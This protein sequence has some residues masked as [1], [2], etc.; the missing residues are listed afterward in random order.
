MATSTAPSA[1]P[2]KSSGFTHLWILIGI[3]IVLAIIAAGLGIQLKVP[4]F[5][6]TKATLGAGL[7]VMAQLV[8]LATLWYGRSLAKKKDFYRHKRVQTSVMLFNIVAIAFVMVVTFREQIVG[9]GAAPGDPVIPIA[10]GHGISGGL[11]ELLGL[12]IVFRMWFEKQLPEWIKFKNFKL[13]MQITIYGWTLVTIGGVAIFAVRY[14]VPAAPVAAVVTPTP[15]PPPPTSTPAPTAAPPTPTPTPAEVTG[16]AAVADERAASDRLNVDLFNVPQ[17]PDGSAYEGWLIGNDGEFRLSVGILAPGAD[18]RVSQSFTSP[19]GE[20]LLANYDEFV[21]T[22]EPVDDS[23]PQPSADIKFS[24]VIPEGPRLAL[25]ALIVSSGDTP[26]TVGY[27][28]GLRAQ[29]QLVDQHVSL[30]DLSMGAQDLAGIRRHA[31]HLVNLIEGL[32]G[33]HY[34]DLDGDG[35]VLDPGDGFGLLSTS[36]GFGYVEA[37]VVHAQTAIDAPDA[38]EQVKLHMEHTMYGAMNAQTWAEQINAQALEMAAAPDVASAQAILEEMRPLAKALLEGVDANGNGQVEPAP[39]EG[40]VYLA[41]A[42]AQ[43]ASSPAYNSPLQEGGA[44]IVVAQATPT[45]TP[46][47]PTVTPTP[48]PQVMQVLMKD[49]AFAPNPVTVKA[50]TTVEFINLDNAPHTAT[51]DDNSKDTGT[52][53]LNG[54]SALVFDTPGEFLYFC[55]FHGGP[56]GVGMA[57]RIVVEP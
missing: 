8:M 41:Y 13:L 53:N 15:T 24:A 12:Y 57:A 56:G 2:K 11:L 4:G 9:P 35:R 7:N 17:P 44:P 51:L 40:T 14:F 30:T 32:H 54:K 34:G 39:G 33:E 43:F 49:F 10:I 29:A 26:G 20:N 55:L 3:T 37:V 21:V 25:R 31:E 6:G 42:H 36:Q 38:T 48:E 28:L 22:L 46:L 27:L 5:L 23:D 52:L 1:A 45:P 18:G 19:A 47:P 16:I 50:G